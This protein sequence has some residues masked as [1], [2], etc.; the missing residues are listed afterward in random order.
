MKST[1]KPPT[2]LFRKVSLLSLAIGLAVATMATMTSC[3]SL[4]EGGGKIGTDYWGEGAYQGTR[5]QQMHSEI[6]RGNF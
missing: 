5:T 3:T 6:Q 4:E 1:E 2:R